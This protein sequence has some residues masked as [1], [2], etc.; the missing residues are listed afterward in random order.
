MLKYTTI[1]KLRKYIYLQDHKSFTT[2]YGKIE[3]DIHEFHD[4]SQ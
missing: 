1:L 2:P 4:I 3:F